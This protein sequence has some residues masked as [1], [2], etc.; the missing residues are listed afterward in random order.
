M[1]VLAKSTVKDSS[2]Y[3]GN[4]RPHT[5]ETDTKASWMYANLLVVNLHVPHYKSERGKSR[6]ILPRSGYQGAYPSQEAWI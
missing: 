5:R 6:T 1:R 3:V 4:V 2:S